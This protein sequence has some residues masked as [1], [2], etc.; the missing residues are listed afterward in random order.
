MLRICS[1]KNQKYL[2]KDKKYFRS[3]YTNVFS[4]WGLSMYKQ[5]KF[6]YSTTNYRGELLL[7]NSVMGERSMCKLSNS[8]HI[9]E[10]KS[11]KPISDESVMS[12]LIEREIYVQNDLDENDKLYSIITSV[13]N[14]S[15]LT[16]SIS[17]TEK[18]NF[19]CVY[20]YES[21]AL[22]LIDEKTQQTI[23]DFVKHNIHKYSGLNIN[24]FGGEPLLALDVIENL[25]KEFMQICTFNRRRYSA[26]ITTN[27]YNLTLD[28]FKKLLKNRIFDYQIT[29]DG[30]KEIHDA[31]RPTKDGKPTFD[32]I[33]TN[34]KNIKG[35]PQ[36]NFRIVLRSNL[37]QTIFAHL[38]EYIDFISE[39][40]GDDNRFNLSICY[41][42]K[43]SDNLDEKVTK[44][45]IYN[46]DSITVLYDRL[47]EEN[48]KIEI[49]SGLTPEHGGCAYGKSNRF[50]IRPNGELHKCSVKFE[51]SKNIVGEFLNGSIKLH[52]NYYKKNI[53]P[54]KCTR[55]EDCFFAP[56]CK[57]EV[58]PSARTDGES[59][60]PDTKKHLHYLLQL[61]DNNGH[62]TVL[63]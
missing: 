2:K 20:C 4:K 8:A 6:N 42:S 49:A 9:E 1:S 7:F 46:R 58:C 3:F 24:W 19:S 47:L 32:R 10:F 16:L 53:K 62:F 22:G 48:K 12:K 45:F 39:I 44:N 31:Q 63:D 36:Q 28:V 34:I 11:K 14:P 43:W 52:D 50:F 26:S 61:L 21:G 55:L 23:I 30:T 13:T 38:D 5:S 25:S 51:N 15:D 57:G 56:I 35:L 29:I 27:G 40:C 60:C 18:C 41:A 33:V 37:T 59:I 17:L 54:Q